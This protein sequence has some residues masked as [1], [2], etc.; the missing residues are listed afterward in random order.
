MSSWSRLGLSAKAKY[1][2]QQCHHIQIHV[3]IQEKCFTVPSWQLRR[4]TLFISGKII[5]FI[6]SLWL[7]LL[8]GLFRS[9]RIWRISLKLKATVICWSRHLPRRRNVQNCKV[10]DRLKANRMGW[11]VTS[12]SPKWPQNMQSGLWVY[13][14]LEFDGICL[15][16]F[17]NWAKT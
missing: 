1:D 14:S 17:L 7:W 4:T 13:E 10:F 16:G 11:H 12:N 6:N 5:C 9:R 8:C 3:K 2:R 15:C